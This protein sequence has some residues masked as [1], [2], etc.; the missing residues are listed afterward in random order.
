M[1]WNHSG[2]PRLSER[3]R[4]FFTRHVSGGALKLA[5]PISSAGLALALAGVFVYRADL[6]G[7]GLAVLLLLSPALLIE[8][9]LRSRRGDGAPRATSPQFTHR[10]SL[11]PGNAPIEQIAAD[12]RLMLWKYE[13]LAR[14]NDQQIPA[15]RLRALEVQISHRA[16]EAARA[17]DLA[18]PD[19]PVFG[20]FD[21]GQL[22]PL[23]R[24]LTA[25]GLVLPP[26]V[27]LLQ[28]DSGF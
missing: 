20:G 8:P 6:H 11:P 16:V 25:E 17:L 7:V 18:H 28:P 15:G 4:R 1:I 2:T 5:V 12:L 19:P 13:I 10:A 22:R 24:A 23:L 14:S 9:G 27:G 26:D 3:I 21:T